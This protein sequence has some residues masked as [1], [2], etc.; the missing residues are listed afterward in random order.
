MACFANIDMI[1]NILAPSIGHFISDD[2]NL[3]F[4]MTSGQAKLRAA[5]VMLLFLC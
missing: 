3:I 1:S 5:W 2:Y 4:G